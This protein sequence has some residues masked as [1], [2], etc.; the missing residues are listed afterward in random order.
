[1]LPSSICINSATYKFASRAAGGVSD[2]GLA[3]CGGDRSFFDPVIL[4]LSVALCER[5][6][7]A[8]SSL[9]LAFALAPLAPPSALL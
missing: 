1:M 3:G 9:A 5:E 6:A 2:V 4:N 8:L 7:L